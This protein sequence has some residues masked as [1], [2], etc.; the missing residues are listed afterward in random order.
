[1]LP[2][3]AGRP[4][5]RPAVACRAG[6]ARCVSSRKAAKRG[7]KGWD[8]GTVWRRGGQ[9]LAP[10][11]GVRPRGGQGRSRCRATQAVGGVG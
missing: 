4:A 7:R 8:G 9:G 3:Q 11:R 6:E 1:M 2:T 5:G 10:R